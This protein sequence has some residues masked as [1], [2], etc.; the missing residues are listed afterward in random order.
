MAF[1]S[2]KEFLEGAVSLR[3]PESGGGGG[4]ERIVLER[5]AKAKVAC[6]HKEVGEKE[7]Q[8]K[9]KKLEEVLTIDRIRA[10]EARTRTRK[11]KEIL[12]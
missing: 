8:I 10:V 7:E 9:S 1:V 2:P 3:G 6:K 4:R 12:L 5:Q 11:K